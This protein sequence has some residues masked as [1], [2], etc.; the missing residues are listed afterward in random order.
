MLGGS[1]YA[2]GSIL[3]SI[4]ETDREVFKDVHT[5]LAALWEIWRSLSAGM[6][7]S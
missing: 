1:F 3:Y 4:F 2:N 5:V 7:S 6:K